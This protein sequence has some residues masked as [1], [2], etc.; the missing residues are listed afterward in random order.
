MAMPARDR[1]RSQRC[2]GRCKILAFE[3]AAHERLAHQPRALVS[4]RLTFESAAPAHRAYQL[5]APVSERP[6]YELAAP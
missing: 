6:T 4:E 5:A 3:L 2:Q 1:V